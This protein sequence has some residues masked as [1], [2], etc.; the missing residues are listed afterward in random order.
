MTPLNKVFMLPA[1]AR[2]TQSTMKAILASGHSRIPVYTREDRS[3]KT[4]Q[5]YG[6]T[7]QQQQQQQQQQQDLRG[8]HERAS[9]SSLFY[10]ASSF[11]LNRPLGCSLT[12]WLTGLAWPQVVGHRPDPGE[13]AAA[14]Q[15]PPGG[16][17]VGCAHAQPAQVGVMCEHC[18]CHLLCVCVCV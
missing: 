12:V 1:D 13:G 16:S 9:P 4:G 11:N 3:V 10:E 17:R 18:E 7:G 14:V 8:H 2:L 6:L 5:G 15:D